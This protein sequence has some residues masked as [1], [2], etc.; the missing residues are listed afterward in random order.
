ML[1]KKRY[2]DKEIEC[3]SC[4]QKI[5]PMLKLNRAKS[6]FFGGRYTGSDKKYWLVCP[7]CKAIIGAK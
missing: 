5:K 3:T 1:F 6:E 2:D 7:I 4:H